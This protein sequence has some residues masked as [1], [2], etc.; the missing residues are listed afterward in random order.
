ML[1]RRRWRSARLAVFD[2]STANGIAVTE[3]L[4]PLLLLL[5]T[6]SITASRHQLRLHVHYALLA[7][8]PRLGRRFHALSRLYTGSVLS[9]SSASGMQSS[10]RL[11]EFPAPNIRTRSSD[12]ALIAGRTAW[13]VP[14]VVWSSPNHHEYVQFQ[15]GPCFWCLSAFR[16][17]LCLVPKISEEVNRKCSATNSMIQLSTPYAPSLSATVHSVTERQTDRQTDK[18]QYDVSTRSYCVQQYD[19]QKN[20]C[21]KSALALFC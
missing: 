6:L 16:R 8:L 17:L 20:W 2:A 1:I 11:A 18:W 13:D 4:P 5:A 21:E 19:R 9:T 14:Y 12:V 15:T 7:R 10:G 3:M